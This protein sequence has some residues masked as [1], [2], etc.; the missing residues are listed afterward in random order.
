M[1]RH[2]GTFNDEVFHFDLADLIEVTE[3]DPSPKGMVDLD[4]HMDIL[5]KKILDKK[6]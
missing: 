1:W 2:I 6:A 4:E 3:A 5:Q